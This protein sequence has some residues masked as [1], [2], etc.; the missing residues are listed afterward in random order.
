MLDS[1]PKNKYIG[2]KK[3]ARSF[4][5]PQLKLPLSHYHETMRSYHEATI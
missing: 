2:E 1:E 3:I 4:P 5:K